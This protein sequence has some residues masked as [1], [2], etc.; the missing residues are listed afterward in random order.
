MAELVHA[1]D[2]LEKAHALL[3]RGDIVAIPTETVYGLAG[4]ATNGRA[5][6]RIFEAKG[7]PR[8]N[9]LIAHVADARH[10]ASDRRLRS[11][12]ARGSPSAS[13]RVR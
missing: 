10:G 13:G 11:A 12:V 7:R 3:D 2:A 8:F 4:D 6:A 9:P 1:N 5:V